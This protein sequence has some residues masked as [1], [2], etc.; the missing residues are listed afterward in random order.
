M[1]SKNLFL[2]AI[3]S[4]A[5]GIKDT[6][7]AQTVVTVF[8]MVGTA[9][10]E[11]QIHRQEGDSTARSNS[12]ERM[13]PIQYDNFTV[14]CSCRSQKLVEIPMWIYLLFML[15]IASIL[16]KLRS[17]VTRADLPRSLLL[18]NIMHAIALFR[19]SGPATLPVLV[20]LKAGRDG[21]TFGTEILY[22]VDICRFT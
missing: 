3:C 11:F 12:R 21:M 5:T 20:I 4:D 14:G 1:F 7:V 22:T 10:E 16:P 17:R 9:D 15:A 6:Y 8:K 13:Q 18:S 19:T 2:V